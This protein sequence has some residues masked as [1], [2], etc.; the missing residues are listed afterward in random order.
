MTSMIASVVPLILL[1]LLII[2]I[3]IVYRLIKK[4]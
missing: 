2:V 1:T 4:L 3:A